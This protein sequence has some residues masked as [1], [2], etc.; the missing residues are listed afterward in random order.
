MKHNPNNKEKQNICTF[1]PFPHQHSMMLPGYWIL[2]PVDTNQN[3][4]QKI[5]AMY[6]LCDIF[7]SNNCNAFNDIIIIFKTKQLIIVIFSWNVSRLEFKI[8]DYLFIIVNV[9]S[10][11]KMNAAEMWW[12][13]KFIICTDKKTKNNPKT[14]LSNNDA[15]PTLGKPKI[16]WM[17]CSRSLKSLVSAHRVQTLWTLNI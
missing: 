12:W 16:D 1:S 2:D 9:Y 3:H 14:C 17:H 8:L 4:S 7:P 5:I 13:D 10:N 15:I 11:F 6:Y